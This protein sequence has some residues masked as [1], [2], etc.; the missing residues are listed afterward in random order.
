MKQSYE[1]TITNLITLT[2]DCVLSGC[3]EQR[4]ANASK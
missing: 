2:N 4:D 1:K 3:E